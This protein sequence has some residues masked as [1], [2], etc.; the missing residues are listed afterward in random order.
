MNMD[1]DGRVEAEDEL[2]DAWGVLE[3]LI[4]FAQ[5][6]EIDLGAELEDGLYVTGDEALT[7]ALVTNLVDNAL[8]Y[9]QPGGHVTVQTQRRDGM[10]IVRVID[11][12]PGIKAEARERVFERFYRAS[13]NAEGTGLGLPIVREIAQRQGGSVTLESNQGGAGLVATVEMRLWIGPT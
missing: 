1:V 2:D 13:S 4:A 7:A 5:S 8:R 6:R 11:N 10:A 3:E 9:T 12:G